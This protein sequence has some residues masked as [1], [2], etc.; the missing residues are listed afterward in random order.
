M[1]NVEKNTK[2]F[3]CGVPRSGTTYIRELMSAVPGITRIVPETGLFTAQGIPSLVN[4]IDKEFAVNQFEKHFWRH[5]YCKNLPWLNKEWDGIATYMSREECTEAFNKFKHRYLTEVDFMP[6]IR[7]LVFDILGYGSFI[8][9][10]PVHCLHIDTIKLVV[11]EAVVIYVER[12]TDLVAKSIVSKPWGPNTLELAR[13]HVENIKYIASRYLSMDKV[14]KI[15]LEDLVVN[16]NGSLGCILKEV[17][18]SGTEVESVFN[19]WED[20]T[21]KDLAMGLSSEGKRIC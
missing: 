17:G 20:V 10:T 3:V 1:T 7:T 9:K 11:P 5:I 21:D 12:D 2:F 19:Y 18:Y 15:C 16:F 4:T 13:R 8:E 14:Y 6:A